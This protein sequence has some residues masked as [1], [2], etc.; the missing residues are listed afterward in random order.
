M[1]TVKQLC[2][3]SVI[4]YRDNQVLLQ[5][6]KDNG[7]WGYTGGAVET[8]EI[9]EEAAKRE[10]FE[11]SGLTAL[12]LKLFGVF[13]GPELYHIYPDG[14]EVHIIDIV[15][16]CSDF[17]GELKPQESEVLDLKWFNYDNIPE[18]LSRPVKPALLKFIEIETQ[19]IE[20]Q[21]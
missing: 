1:G 14:N 15:F 17:T 3:A 12:S 16:T 10:M 19:R 5:Q 11:E 4:I 20:V 9:V 18:N 6:R 21:I 13:S 2:G 8:G 7:T